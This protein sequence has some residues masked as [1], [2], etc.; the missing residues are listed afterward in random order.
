MTREFLARH[1]VSANE[2]AARLLAEEPV[3]LLHSN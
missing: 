1:F 3:S 2:I